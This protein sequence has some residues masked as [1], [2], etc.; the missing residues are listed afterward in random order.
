MQTQ[1]DTKMT[2]VIDIREG[3]KIRAARIAAGRELNK[4]I[5]RTPVG[6][7]RMDGR[8]VRRRPNSAA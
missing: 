2:K 1:I 5:A 7:P 8:A 4:R 6:Q 3:H